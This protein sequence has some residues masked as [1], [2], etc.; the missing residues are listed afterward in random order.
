MRK[1]AVLPLLALAVLALAGTA[2]ACP[3]P[4]SPT[5]GPVRAFVAKHEGRYS[6]QARAEFAAAEARMD[7]L[8]YGVYARTIQLNSKT[9]GSFSGPLAAG[10]RYCNEHV[11][12]S[13]TRKMSY[14]LKI[15]GL[16]GS[17]AYGA[18]DLHAWGWRPGVGWVTMGVASGTDPFDSMTVNYTKFWHDSSALVGPE[19]LFSFGQSAAEFGCTLT[20]G[21][22]IGGTGGCSIPNSSQFTL[23]S[24]MYDLDSYCVNEVWATGNY[25]DLSYRTDTHTSHFVP[26]F[27]THSPWDGF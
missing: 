21:S 19:V 11:S 18:V 15:Y 10:Q 9:R 7:K 16:A 20:V 3:S 24:T 14:C 13:S 22:N 5:A 4:D 23:Y 25:T 2:V 1:L 27:Y 8:V 6:T 26:R 12:E 17:E